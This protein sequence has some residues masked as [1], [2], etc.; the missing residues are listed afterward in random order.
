MDKLIGFTTSNGE[1]HLGYYTTIVN[2]CGDINDSD[3]IVVLYT[4]EYGN[5]YRDVIEE[6]DVEPITCYYWDKEKGEKQLLP[7]PKPTTLAE[8]TAH[9][10][11][12]DLIT[13]DKSVRT[14]YLQMIRKWL[15]LNTKGTKEIFIDKDFVIHSEERIEVNSNVINSIPDYIRIAPDA[16]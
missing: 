1:K 5:E 12:E 10:F 8:R 9:L 4:D 15:I 2:P 3:C 16:K 6:Y 7:A 11:S 13:E 14:A